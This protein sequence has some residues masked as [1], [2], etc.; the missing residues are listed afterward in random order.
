MFT[1]VPEISRLIRNISCTYGKISRNLKI[2]QARKIEAITQPYLVNPK[3]GKIMT[4]NN[5]N[6]NVFLIIAWF[7]SDRVQWFIHWS[8]LMTIAGSKAAN[9]HRSSV[10]MVSESNGFWNKTKNRT[11]PFSPVTKIVNYSRAVAGKQKEEY[12]LHDIIFWTLRK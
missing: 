9:V 1:N 5:K 6:R 2:I 8:D 4:I 3:D 12:Y 10:G 7:L 11:L